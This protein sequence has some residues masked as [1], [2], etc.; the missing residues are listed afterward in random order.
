V[1]GVRQALVIAGLPRASRSTNLAADIR[2]LFEQRHLGPAARRQGT[3]HDRS[4]HSTAS[5]STTSEMR[6]RIS[7]SS[8]DRVRFP[9]DGRTLIIESNSNQPV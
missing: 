6:R 1:Q 3:M 8:T 7:G 5:L 4:G 9:W 2:Q